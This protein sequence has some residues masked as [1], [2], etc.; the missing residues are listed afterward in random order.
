MTK[1]P[2]GSLVG[3]IVIPDLHILRGEYQRDM[4]QQRGDYAANAT[5]ADGWRVAFDLRD[6]G[7]HD[8]LVCERANLD[9]SVASV[10][11]DAQ[12]ITGVYPP[13]TKT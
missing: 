3:W 9:G 6:D 1:L 5:P 10:V 8:G 7:L 2:S 4:G 12:H 13:H 11:W